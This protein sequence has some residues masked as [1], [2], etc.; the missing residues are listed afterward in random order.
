MSTRR[1]LRDLAEDFGGKI[2]AE[3]KKELRRSFRGAVQ[4]TVDKA[5]GKASWSH[6]IPGATKLA[7]NLSARPGIRIVVN[8]KQAPHARPYEDM[9]RWG[10]F[11]HPVFGNR[12]VWVAQRSRPFLFNTVAGDADRI[13]GEIADVIP[14]VARR[15]G[16]H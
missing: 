15:F 5:R 12:K 11:R 7:T 1:Q 8:A 3:V 14:E 9:G 6:R 13:A 2:P 10:A 16:F 4:P